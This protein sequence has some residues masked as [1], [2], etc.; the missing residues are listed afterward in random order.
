MSADLYTETPPTAEQLEAAMQFQGLL[1]LAAG[2]IQDLK[3]Q[4]QFKDRIITWLVHNHCVGSKAQI[5]KVYFDI[6]EPLYDLIAF[7]DEHSGDLKLEARKTEQRI[8]Q[9]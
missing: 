7:A 4:C 6:T 8:I 1:E 2:Q 3:A 9:P 5:P